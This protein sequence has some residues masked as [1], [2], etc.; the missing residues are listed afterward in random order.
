ME[1]LVRAA[2]EIR[3][4]IFELIPPEAEVTKVD[5]EG[6]KIA[7]YSRK[8][9][10]FLENNG[11]LVKK[12]AKAL[13]KRVIVR[14]D[15]D[16]RMNEKEAE[17]LIKSLIPSEAKL[18]DIFFNIIT[19]EVEIEVLYPEK[20][21]GQVLYEILA[22]TLWHPKL[23]RKPPLSSR[24]VKEIR[25]LY[26]SYA[27]E[28]LK[29]LH[30]L[31]Y[32]IYRKPLFEDKYVRIVALGSFQ[33]VGRSAILV[34]TPDSNILLDAGIKPTSNGDE[35]PFFDLPEF[36]VE[37]LDAVVVTHAHLDHCGIVPYLY[38]YGYKGPVYMTEPT[39]HLAK[40]LYD[41]Y[42]KIAER[43]GRKAPYGIRDVASTLLHAYT[44]SYGEVTDI[45]PDTKLTLYRSG[46]IIGS[47]LAHL[48]IGEGLLNIV[49]TGDI[50]YANT[51][52]LEKAHTRFPRVE[53][54]IIESTYGG[55]EDRLPDEMEAQLQLL[56]VVKDTIRR[57]GVVLIPVLAIGRAQEILL[58]LISLIKKKALEEIPIFIEGMMNEVSAVHTA[59]PEYLS[60]RIRNLI[61]QGEN[62]FTAENIHI[63]RNENRED[64]ASHRPSV[65]LATSG[66][67]TGGPVLDYLRIL[68]DDEKSSL[69]FVSYQVEG[70]LGR[71]ILQGL[72]QLTFTGER[73]RKIIRELKMRVYRVEGF[74]GH[75]DRPQLARYIRHISPTPRHI[76]LNHGER[77]KIREFKSFLNYLKRKHGLGYE[78]SSPQNMEA[79]RL[80]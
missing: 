11:E 25:A 62:P 76:I 68:A 56:E 22:K 39:L 40:L 49:Y 8:P 9:H 6:P 65:I 42:L 61:Y 48:H 26:R 36:N 66:M 55:N 4:V 78:V 45:S 13:K 34:Q 77:N 63:V 41:D 59:F 1:T 10:L 28:R 60:S 37:E 24:T 16:S 19:G 51:M 70:T 47:A 14:G 18:Q 58:S 79:V 27:E 50:K 75:S 69:V 46:H 17:A 64:I 43:E 3:K 80:Y 72:R 32:R 35:L 53:V 71:R 7:I 31:G 2:V 38:K 29:F 33:E 20:V 52:L 12:V 57:G 73:G 74:S 44:L 54:L 67:L 30:Q 5:F 21:P 23:I 15:P